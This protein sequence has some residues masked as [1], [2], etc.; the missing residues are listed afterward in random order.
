M[1]AQRITDFTQANGKHETKQPSCPIQARLRENLSKSRQ[2][3][4]CFWEKLP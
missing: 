4:S 2:K 1:Q 3:Q